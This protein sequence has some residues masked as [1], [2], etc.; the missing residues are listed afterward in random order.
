MSVDA[1]PSVEG[2]HQRVETTRQLR[3]KCP[4]AKVDEYTV[5]YGVLSTPERGDESYGV[6]MRADDQRF[7]EIVIRVGASTVSVTF[8]G[9]TGDDAQLVE[10]V[11]AQATEK[12]RQAATG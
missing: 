12:L 7:D 3:Q 9:T 2:A 4:V 5:S 1:Y 11:T 8:A 6:R 10:A